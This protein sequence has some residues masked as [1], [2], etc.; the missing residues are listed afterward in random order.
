M[1]VE[2]ELQALAEGRTVPRVQLEEEQWRSV[3]PTRPQQRRSLRMEND[4]A[5]SRTGG[6][7]SRSSWRRAVRS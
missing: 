7:Q 6:G 2:A 3:S 4:P 5:C 1:A